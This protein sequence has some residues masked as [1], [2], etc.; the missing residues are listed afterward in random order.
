M[1]TPEYEYAREIDLK[2]S[3]EQNNAIFEMSKINKFRQQLQGLIAQEQKEE[4]CGS[5]KDRVQTFL[6]EQFPPP[7]EEDED[8]YQKFNVG[9]KVKEQ[10]ALVKKVT[11]E[12]ET[13]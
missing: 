7:Y 3:F 6:T 4:L 8:E 1:S 9:S 11:F 5:Q 10:L 2:C 13:Q 12:E